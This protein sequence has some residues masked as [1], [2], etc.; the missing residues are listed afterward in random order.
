MIVIKKVSFLY[1]TDII[2]KE[3]YFLISLSENSGIKEVKQIKIVHHLF[4]ASAVK[5][6][7]VYPT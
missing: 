3:N 5:N 6:K 2:W 1:V 4:L 7:P